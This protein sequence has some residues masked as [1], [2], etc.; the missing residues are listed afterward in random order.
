M[1]LT[2]SLTDVSKF[3]LDCQVLLHLRLM[4]IKI[5]INEEI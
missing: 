4:Y 3:Y 1:D 5:L 2:H